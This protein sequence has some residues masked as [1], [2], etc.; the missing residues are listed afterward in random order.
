MRYST[1]LSLLALNSVSAFKTDVDHNNEMTETVRADS[2]YSIDEF[3]DLVDSVLDACDSNGCD[4]GTEKCNIAHCISIDGDNLDDNHDNI[5]EIVG[6]Y[7]KNSMKTEDTT[8]SDCTSSG[9]GFLDA[10]N[11]TIPGYISLRRNYD[12]DDPNTLYKISISTSE[13]KDACGAVFDALSAAGGSL[14][15]ADLFGAIKVAV[16]TE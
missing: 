8:I 14:G 6:E 4:S 10:T 12:N 3:N 16:C 15:A 7:I 11:Y 1:V 9:C 2:G 5:L 13:S